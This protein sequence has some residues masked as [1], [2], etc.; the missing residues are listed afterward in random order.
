MLIIYTKPVA[1]SPVGSIQDVA[2][3]LGE[4][5]IRRGVARRVLPGDRQA[6]ADTKPQDTSLPKRKYVRKAVKAN[7]D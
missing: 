2:V 4:L 7:D 5:L 3:P 6:F 1:N